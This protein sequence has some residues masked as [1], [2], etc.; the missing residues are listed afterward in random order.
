MKSIRT[1][2]TNAVPTVGCQVYITVA[3][4]ILSLPLFAG[5]S[6]KSWPN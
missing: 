3:Y 1:P 6:K 4:L 2:A 5:C